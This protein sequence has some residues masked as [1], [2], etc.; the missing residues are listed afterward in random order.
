MVKALVPILDSAN[1]ITSIKFTP[2]CMRGENPLWG[3]G[4]AYKKLHGFGI[5]EWEKK[6]LSKLHLNLK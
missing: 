6:L 3:H 4:A 2:L 5:L 1:T